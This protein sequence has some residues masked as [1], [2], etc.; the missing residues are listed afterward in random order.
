M[1]QQNRYKVS[2][3]LTKIGSRFSGWHIDE[4]QRIILSYKTFQRIM[5]LDEDAEPVITYE[6]TAR[7]KYQLLK[8]LGF[9]TDTGV[10]NL[11]EIKRFMGVEE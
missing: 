6:R 5:M 3:I 8:D 10:M 1:P 11:P 4:S 7:E 9:L 2:A